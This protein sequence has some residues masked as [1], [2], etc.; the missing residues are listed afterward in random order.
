MENLKVLESLYD[1]GELK[2]IILNAIDSMVLNEDKKVRLN[3]IV[4]G[5]AGK[6]IPKEFYDILIANHTEICKYNYD[7]ESDSYYED[8][9]SKCDLF[10]E[11]L[12]EWCSSQEDIPYK[13]YI[14]LSLG[15]SDADGDLCTF[16]SL[17]NEFF[18]THTVCD[19][20]GSVECTGYVTS[21]GKS[22]CKDCY[23]VYAQEQFEYLWE[24]GGGFMHSLCDTICKADYKNLGLL[25]KAY[26]LLVDG[27]CEYSQ[28]HLFNER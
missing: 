4:V 24:N 19:K 7:Y 28:G 1:L 26:P 23:E 20:C 3:T 13:E 14:S 17:S 25:Y 16:I 21:Y 8:F 12:N 9:L 18:E 27:Y 15:T 2:K 5:S 6:Y 11:A 22:I 10:S